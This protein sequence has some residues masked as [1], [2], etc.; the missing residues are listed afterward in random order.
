[1]AGTIGDTHMVL[2]TCGVIVEATRTMII[3][4]ELLTS[5]VDFGFLDC[6]V[7]DVTVMLSC[8]ARRVSNNGRV[9]LGGIQ[10]KKIQELVWLVRDRQNLGYPI[11]AAL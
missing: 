10:I 11:D 1:M 2:T 8:M 5:I 9:I 7:D 3:N 6:G 4:N